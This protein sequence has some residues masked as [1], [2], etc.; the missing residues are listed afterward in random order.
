MFRKPISI[1]L[2]IRAK[3]SESEPTCDRSFT[4]N[5]VRS[6]PG[7]IKVKWIALLIGL[8]AIAFSFR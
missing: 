3:W 8:G 2:S 6:H 4:Q 7:S 1:A 5:L